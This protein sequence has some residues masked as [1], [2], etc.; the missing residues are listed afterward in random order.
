VA[1]ASESNGR[2]WLGEI[3]Y[4]GIYDVALTAE[5]VETNA[6]IPYQAR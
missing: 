4:V 1:G 5:E 2:F 3:Y 6:A